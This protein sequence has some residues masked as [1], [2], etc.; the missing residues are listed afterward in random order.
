MTAAEMQYVRQ[1]F[2][3]LAASSAVRHDLRNQRCKIRDGEAALCGCSPQIMNR[4]GAFE[5][6]LAALAPSG[7]KRT[8]LA[9]KSR[10]EAAD[11]QFRSP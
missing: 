4:N 8:S 3:L 5:L 11:A 10:K 2:S 6:M 1:R 9:E 7:K